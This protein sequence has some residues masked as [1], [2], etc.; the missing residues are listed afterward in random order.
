MAK[1][2]E[3]RERGEGGLFHIK[4]SPNWYIKVNGVRRATGTDV[5]E[6]A[7]AKLRQWQ[8]RASIGVRE[9]NTQL[10]YEDIRDGLLAAYRIGKQNGHSLVTRADG[11]ETIWGLDHLNKFFEGKKVANITTQ[12][13]KQFSKR[14]LDEGASP[15]TVNRN[16]GLLRRMFYQKRKEDTTT[17]LAIPYFPMMKEPEARKGFLQDGDFVKLFQALPERLRTFVLLLYTSGMRS[18]EA[19]KVHWEYVDLD[20][21]EIHLPGSITKSGKPRIVPL[22]DAVVERM[23]AERKESGVVFPVGNYIKAWCTACVKAGLGVR[24]KG[25]QNGGYGTYEG[26]IPHDFRRSAILNMRRRGV[27]TTVAKAISGHLTDAVFERYNI[28]S[29]EDLH[30]AANRVQAGSKVLDVK[31]LPAVAS[32]GSIIEVGSNSGQIA[33]RTSVNKI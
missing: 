17:M 26:L 31:M 23:K 10:K 13:L 18:G 19:K 24:T 1:R 7:L 6:E 32:N 30:D 16:L 12:T 27:S 25:N 14:R 33:R 15:S 4:G 11:S 21:R 5:K 2:K 29:T 28:T 3:P 8:G 20:G 22:V 9:A